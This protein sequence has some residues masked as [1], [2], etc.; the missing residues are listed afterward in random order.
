[1]KFAQL[2]QRRGSI[3][4]ISCDAGLIKWRLDTEM[5][6]GARHTSVNFHDRVHSLSS[7]AQ[8]LFVVIAPLKASALVKVNSEKKRR[9]RKK[10]RGWGSATYH[11]GEHTGI[12]D[13]LAVFE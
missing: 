4:V 7:V 13:P 8:S 9:R 2:S 6:T 5:G 11:L 10:H 3:D 12:L 1:M